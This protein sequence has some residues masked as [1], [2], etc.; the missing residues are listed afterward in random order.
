MWKT[1]QND[2]QEIVDVLFSKARKVERYNEEVR[3]NREMLKNIVDAVFYLGRQEM[4][5]RGHDE[6]ATSLNQGNYREL[7]KSLVS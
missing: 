2:R 4:T 7:L 6:S 1:F 3:Q 5:F